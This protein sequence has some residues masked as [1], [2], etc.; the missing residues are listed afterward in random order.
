MIHLQEAIIAYYS[1]VVLGVEVY[2]EATLYVQML[3]AL[4]R[5]ELSAD[6]QEVLDIEFDPSNVYAFAPS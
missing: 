1:R 6:L 4:V 2:E 5:Q 3:K